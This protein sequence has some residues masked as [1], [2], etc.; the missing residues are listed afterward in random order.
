ML[1]VGIESGTVCASVEL[2]RILLQPPIDVTAI[3]SRA[4]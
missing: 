2:L 1:R 3:T 4:G